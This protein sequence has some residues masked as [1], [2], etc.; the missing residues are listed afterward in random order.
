MDPAWEYDRKLPVS[1]G[2]MTYPTM[3]LAEMSRLNI[4]S[5]AAPS[6]MLACWMTGT[7]LEEQLEV[8]RMWGFDFITVVGFWVKLNETAELTTEVKDTPRGKKRTVITIDGG[9]Y[10]GLGSYANLNV[11]FLGLFK[12][13]GGG[14]LERM[15]T[16]VK[17][18]ILEP[19]LA[20]IG[21]HSV[22]PAIYDR[23]DAIFGA[24][25]SI[26]FWARPNAKR[27]RHWAATG[28]DQDGLDIREL[29]GMRTFPEDYP[30]D[31][32]R[33]SWNR[34]LKHQRGS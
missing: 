14:V 16:D 29:C 11:E 3:P 28:L 19:M 4:L 20:P 21:D 24:P 15:A 8:I 23:L 26:E 34:I 7:K 18:L 30:H 22:K 10:S 32:R 25:P 27:P 31:I 33:K 9:L 6:C 5:M 13:R 1:M 17:Q 12:R 2:G